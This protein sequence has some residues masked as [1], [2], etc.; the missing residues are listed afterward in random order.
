M[1][2]RLLT[3]PS[4]RD[5]EEEEVEKKEKLSGMDRLNAAR[6]KAE[7]PAKKEEPAAPQQQ[8]SGMERLN[9]A[10]E[11]QEKEAA[12]PQISNN[13][14]EVDTVNGR[15]RTRS[16]DMTVPSWQDDPEEL[17]AE[18]KSK[19]NALQL[20]QNALSLAGAMK[21]AADQTASLYEKSLQKYQGIL[22][23]DKSTAAEKYTA[24]KNLEYLKPAYTELKLKAQK[25]DSTYNAGDQRLGQLQESYD[26]SR[27]KLVRTLGLG[28]A[29]A[30]EYEKQ[31]QSLRNE[32]DKQ[33]RSGKANSMTL[34]RAEDLENRAATSR[35]NYAS[36]LYLTEGEEAANKYAAGEREK[37]ETTSL[38]K[39]ILNTIGGSAAN[40]LDAAAS[41]PLLMM[42]RIMEIPDDIAYAITKDE[43]YRQD[44]NSDA[45][46]A[47]N[48]FTPEI[49]RMQQNAG[50]L[51]GKIVD[52]A[53]T[54]GN[55]MSLSA[56]GGAVLSGTKA[57]ALAEELGSLANSSPLVTSAATRMGAKVGAAVLGDI[58]RNPGNA[59][60]SASAGLNAYTTALDNGASFGDAVANG[61]MQAAAEYFSNKM[62]SGTPFE[63]VEGQKGYVTQI[64]EK[65]AEKLGKSK[66]LK[67][68]NA[69]TGGKVLNWLFDKAG[70]GMEE[71]ITAVLD[72]LIEYAT[73]NPNGGVD[74]KLDQLIEE[75]EGGVLLSL[76]MSGGE[77]ALKPS[78]ETAQIKQ[79]LMDMGYSKEIAN[80]YAPQ[81][82]KAF[83]AAEKMT[84][85]IQKAAEQT[86]PETTLAR[87]VN[88]V[89][90]GEALTGQDARKILRDPEA[91]QA[92]IDAGLITGREMND[93]AGRTKVA[94]AAEQYIRQ[95]ETERETAPVPQAEAAETVR[96]T[97]NNAQNGQQNAQ[98]PEKTL[99][100]MDRLNAARAAMEGQ[101]GRNSK[102]ATVVEHL[103]KNAETL[104]RGAPVATIDGNEIPKS[105][106]ATDRVMA[107]LSTIGNKV[108][109]EG[110]GDVLFSRSKVKTAMIGHGASNAKVET[111]AAVPAVIKNGKLIDHIENYE[112]R[113]YDSYIF[114][115]PVTYKGTTTLVGVVVDKDKVTGRYYVHEVVDS[116]GNIIMES[117]EPE[118]TVDRPPKRDRPVV[119]SSSKL[120]IPQSEQTVNKPRIRTEQAEETLT[121]AQKPVNLLVNSRTEA[122]T[123]GQ[124]TQTAIGAEQRTSAEAETNGAALPDRDGGRE[125]GERTRELV[126]KLARGSKE[127]ARLPQRIKAAR[128]T[129]SIRSGLAV[130][131]D[132]S[133]LGV[134][135]AVG[136]I[137][138]YPESEWEDDLR[139]IAEKVG[140]ATGMKVTFVLGEI[141]IQED[142]KPVKNVRGVMTG[143]RILVQANHPTISAAKLA[144]HEAFHAWAYN[145]QQ[146]YI[147][148]ANQMWNR[149]NKDLGREQAEKL[150][151]DYM[152]RT[153][154]ITYQE[155]NKLSTLEER[156]A[157]FYRALEE[158]CSDA[159]GGIDAYKHK[160]SKYQQFVR[161]AVRGEE[162]SAATD[163]R[164][165]P[166]GRLQLPVP[167]YLER[168]QSTAQASEEQKSKAE[169]RQTENTATEP[170]AFQDMGF[171]QAD[172]NSIAYARAEDYWD[173]EEQA[174]AEA[175]RDL[176]YEPTFYTGLLLK[177]G[178]RVDGLA[179]GNRILVQSDNRVKSIQQIAEEITGKKLNVNPDIDEEPVSRAT[180]IAG[181]KKNLRQQLLDLFSIP[182]GNRAEFGNII[183]KYADLAIRNGGLTADEQNE[184]FDALYNAGAIIA[185]TDAAFQAA[186]DAVRGMKIY[187]P[188]SVKH[189]FGDDWGAFRREAF[190]Q[191]I[192]LTDN[193]ADKD[194][195][196]SGHWGTLSQ[197]WPG[198]F[199]ENETSEAT[200]LET[201]VE[202]A[203]TA[204]GETIT[205]YERAQ[206]EAGF[207][208]PEEEYKSDLRAQMRAALQELPDLTGGVRYSTAETTED[209]DDEYRQ[210]PETP[211][212]E[213]LGIRLAG[214]KGRYEL[215]EQLIARDK[216]AKSLNRAL[217]KAERKLK[218]TAAEKE[219]ASGLAAGIYKDVSIPKE[220]DRAKVLE[221]ADYYWAE[222]SMDLNMLQEVRADINAEL[223]TE[224][225]DLLKDVDNFKKLGMLWMNER[226][227]DRIFRAMFGAEKGRE[228]F[229]WLIRPEQMNE[230]EKTRW[231]EAQLDKVRKFE[232]SKGKTR[233]LTREESELTMLVMEGKAA[234][235]MVADMEA[236]GL[237]AA[238]VKN[239]AENIRNGEDPADA[240]EE[241]GLKAKE[242]D[243]AK[244]Y[245]V[246]M[247][248]Q[249]KLKD[250]DSKIIE[251]AAETYSQIF[252]EFYDAINDFLVAHGYEPIGYIKGYAPHM[253]PEETQN[254]LEKAFDKMGI[255]L[256]NDKAQGLPASIAGETAYFKPNKRWDPYFLHRTGTLAEYDIEKAYQSYVGYMADILFHTDDIMRARNFE[257]MIRKTFA[258]ENIRDELDWIGEIRNS[259]TDERLSMLRDAGKVDKTT[260]L[261]AAETAEK[262][263]AWEEELYNNI[264][265]DKTY[266]NLVMWVKN[267]ANILAG[268]QSMADRGWEYSVGRNSLNFANRLQVAFQRSL[269][270]GS[271][272][273]ALNQTAQLPMIKAEL[274][275]R[276][277]IQAALDI[278]RGNT[279]NF[280]RDS[281]FLTG[282]HGVDMLTTEN[283]DKFINALYTPSTVVDNIVSTIA[284]RGAYLKAVKQGQS[285]SE[286]MQTADDFGRKV[287]GSREKGTRPL[288]YESK[289][290]FSRMIHMFQVEAANSWDHIASD[291]PYEIK[292]IAKT[293]GKG[294][295]VK[296]LIALLVRG[297]LSAFV[298]NRITEEVYGGTPAPF[299]VIGL[300]M[301]FVASGQGMTTNRYLK[302][303]IDNGLEKIG[304]DRFFGTE[305]VDTEFDVGKGLEE[306][307]YNVMNDVPLLRNLAG[308]FG[309][310]DQTVPL[311]GAGGEFADMYNAVKDLIQNGNEGKQVENLIRA[312]LKF[313]FQLFPAGRQI[314]KTGEGVEAVIRGGSY[315]KKGNLQYPIDDT[316]DKVKAILFGKNAT[317]AAQE[318]WA[319]GEGTLS[320]KQKA[321]VKTMREWGVSGEDA[322]KIVRKISKIKQAGGS[323]KEAVVEYIGGL[324]LTSGQKDQI[325]LA[326]NYA[327]SGLDETPWH[328]KGGSSGKGKTYAKSGLRIPTPERVETQSKPRIRKE[329]T[330]ATISKPRIRT[331]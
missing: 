219:F 273:S 251:T 182:Q 71:V 45:L 324:T 113:G 12:T 214:S 66:V 294:K 184:L 34:R 317:N 163:R 154:G 18:T 98:N 77:A 250:A 206:Q 246:W 176:G 188:E 118:S 227:P 165:G 106:R 133:R 108:T 161:K 281:D 140:K 40:F 145:N 229:D 99:T 10:R 78:M 275:D 180:Q 330:A 230:A 271:L 79:Q 136:E 60:I 166:P 131:Y 20:T 211:A 170:T 8:L 326:Q 15:I 167:E 235:A 43:R 240:A 220:L 114:A 231:H 319:S 85:A 93:S 307:G 243:L 308:V 268:K 59:A 84:Q 174:A 276:W 156:K 119:N 322:V 52:I 21:Q 120:N 270:A 195:T 126:G 302:T 314:T 329:T 82:R 242:K 241:F 23:D 90:Q 53:G 316:A 258:D 309:W 293:Q 323:Q 7:E 129:N 279:K 173:A 257:R 132:A 249:K 265:E 223:Q 83:K 24:A 73:Y 155:S 190:G 153:L 291:L 57:A 92:L 238:A 19:G 197:T 245:A 297:L 160:A 69:S 67:T 254:L 96:A 111:I 70:E 86:T 256:G 289:G 301:N 17:A 260:M 181:P 179:E 80:T 65:A 187:V 127:W 68:F 272:T 318:H 222:K 204:G 58:A 63:D 164:T 304:Q 38:G 285:Y 102:T 233:A 36:Y 236:N 30:K 171:A 4:L 196:S 296:T 168:G 61:V 331:T 198:M 149:L 191:R 263:N 107:F 3:L 39:K 277:Y 175:L 213:K 51:G 32:A 41:A 76:L 31:A 288:A 299:D 300:A 87:I 135:N 138:V 201:I 311:P 248:T 177:D 109:R 95:R 215:S 218:A 252:D 192:Y 75:F 103:R 64:I 193:P 295:A 306:L 221:L 91:M 130:R 81:I 22:D 226:T 72:P 142:G 274:G 321:L 210:T 88:K 162:T 56:F 200:M 169:R 315:N 6:G 247:D 280:W 305:D 159:Y 97:E 128:R 264:K 203:K 183:N 189:E 157:A 9:A 116:N 62:F 205:P 123:N 89:T 292:E 147:D 27:E 48:P 186:R 121:P 25:A 172:E 35:G 115:A 178:E 54:A 158:I 328:A 194:V 100:G 152:Q 49:Q 312:T 225:E 261:S 325:Y 207:P 13:Y 237:D 267:W 46:Q 29:K 5:E 137:T 47:A 150:L 313:G 287:M 44:R 134:R 239:A 112:G 259:P 26:Q 284:V 11:K 212:L 266:D 253:Q 286:A 139:N 216:A 303:I 310:G 33:Y 94:N 42:S 282:K 202:V 234:A 2:S 148:L 37:E 262:L 209:S 74:I 28:E 104:L 146:K 217:K 55:M 298:L 16:S 199:A 141:A 117:T 269:V 224:A 125:S 327:E 255:S 1:K 290:L 208:I 50:S 143:E 228:I 14:R 320:E 105:G 110:F 101:Q 151:A 144:S 124:Q 232:D 122:N 185:G 283:W 278:L 244:N